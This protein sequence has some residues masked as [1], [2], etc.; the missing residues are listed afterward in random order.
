MGL[1]EPKMPIHWK[2]IMTHLWMNPQTK[3]PRFHIGKP[4]SKLPD[5][6]VSSGEHTTFDVAHTQLFVLKL[7][8]ING[9]KYIAISNHQVSSFIDKNQPSTMLNIHHW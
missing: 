2:P 6:D 9:N 4:H 8:I 1:C 7:L 3:L 5:Q